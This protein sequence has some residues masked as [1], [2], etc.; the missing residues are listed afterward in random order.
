V[1]IAI[2][3][4]AKPTASGN[5]PIVKDEAP[6][7]K[8]SAAKVEVPSENWTLAAHQVTLEEQPMRAS[9]KSIV[10]QLARRKSIVSPAAIQHQ[11]N[12]SISALS[13]KGAT[14]DIGSRRGT[15][16]GNYHVKASSGVQV[17]LKI[18][19]DGTGELDRKV[20]IM[21][22][23]VKMPT[24]PIRSQ[25]GQVRAAAP[26]G[27][28]T[29]FAVPVP[30]EKI[31]SM[32]PTTAKARR[33]A[34]SYKNAVSA[35]GEKAS[36]EEWTRMLQEGAADG[37][38]DVVTPFTQ[39][40]CPIL[41]EE[42]PISGEPKRLT[43][44]SEIGFIDEKENEKVARKATSVSKVVRINTSKPTVA[45][46]KIVVYRALLIGNDNDFLE[47]SKV[48]NLFRANALVPEEAK[49]FEMPAY[50]GSPEVP[51]EVEIVVERPEL[52][53]LCCYPSSNA[54]MSNASDSLKFYHKYK[55]Y[56]LAA[57]FGGLTF[58][59][60]VIIVVVST[61]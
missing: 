50:T 30:K 27:V 17:P 34:L 39:I 31:E 41:E 49:L 59:F 38:F 26:A 11:K 8:S 4:E 56:L 2:T 22:V 45:A 14:S 25:A 21:Q 47:Y 7:R 54:D 19:T 6:S 16:S 29:R 43:E 32:T 33:R 9:R 15:T 3:E 1:V 42:E 24:S 28:I 36:I 44:Y 57:I 5:R 48:R 13:A 61:K 10:A 46:P 58:T 60:I 51:P 12:G 23:E 35:S 52:C 40:Q 37:D 55:C 20:T 53:E 18:V